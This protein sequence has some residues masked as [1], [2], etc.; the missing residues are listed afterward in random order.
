MS[1]EEQVLTPTE[2]E[3]QEE[4]IED[5]RAKYESEAERRSSLEDQYK[6][7]QRQ[8]NKA[9]QSSVTRDDLTALEDRLAAA[10][11]AV[12]ESDEYEEE[13]PKKRLSPSEIIKQQREMAPKE[14]DDPRET[15]AAEM[16]F[17]ILQN[18]FGLKKGT[19]EFEAEAEKLYDYDP[20]EALKVV[21]AKWE[22]ELKRR[23]IEEARLESA[24]KAKESGATKPDGGPSA[25]SDNW[26]AIRDRYI[27]NPDDPKNYSDWIKVKDHRPK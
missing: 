21:E 6:N 11:E 3:P 23:A 18:K 20:S 19:P 27:N 22:A 17:D 5:W 13:K 1:E 24:R 9:R 8:L 15:M 7:L 12:R 2:E 26:F 10:L 4:P 25:S 14:A 16:V